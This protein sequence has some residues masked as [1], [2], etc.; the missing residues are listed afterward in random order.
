MNLFNKY[1]QTAYVTTILIAGILLNSCIKKLDYDF[2]DQPKKLV[3]NSILTPDSLVKVYVSSTQN[4]LK[5][6]TII[7]D[8][9]VVLLYQNNVFYD[10]LTYMGKGLYMPKKNL[11]PCER[12][13][14]KVI[15][16]ASGYP[17]ADAEVKIPVLNV[18][19]D[20]HVTYPYGYDQNHEPISLF[21]L[22]FKDAPGEKNY[23]ELMFYVRDSPGKFNFLSWGDIKSDDNV[24]KDE[25][26]LDYY[27]NTL[28]ISD[29]LFNGNDVT[30][31]FKISGLTF[32]PI[33]NTSSVPVNNFLY[34][35]LRCVSE[36]HYK[37]KKYL[38]RHNYNQNNSGSLD[39]PLHLL[40]SGEPSNMYTNINGGYGIF[41]GYSG[42]MKKIKLN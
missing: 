25:G 34:V 9:A 4:I 5:T 8:N 30:V 36:S 21:E 40:F 32:R 31:S 18:N 14:Y 16:K 15:V 37:Y 28:L 6:D 17:D 13:V 35:V 7:I 12:C 41:V 1:S 39:D 38:L 22:T 26:D 42:I 23:Y 20:V 27:I 3:I 24:L 19:Y 11:Y 29:K 10:T 33:N 2:K